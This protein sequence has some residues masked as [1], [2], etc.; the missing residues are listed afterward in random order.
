MMLSTFII[1]RS[2]PVV[3]FLT[4]NI[5]KSEKSVRAQSNRDT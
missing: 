5:G 4:E 1:L 3:G 2:S